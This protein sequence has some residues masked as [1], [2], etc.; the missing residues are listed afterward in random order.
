MAIEN[1]IR[2]LVASNETTEDVIKSL[3]GLVAKGT[4]TQ[5]YISRDGITTRL[6]KVV[7]EGHPL[8][9]KYFLTLKGKKVEASCLE[10]ETQVAEQFFNQCVEADIL[11]GVLTKDRYILY[12]ADHP[13]DHNQ[14]LEVV[15]DDFTHTEGIRQL[16]IIEIEYSGMSEEDA[17]FQIPRP[18]L[19]LLGYEVTNDFAFSNS[20]LTNEEFNDH[21]N[22]IQ[23]YLL[24]C[25]PIDIARIMLER[26]KG[27]VLHDNCA[28]VVGKVNHSLLSSG[29]A[30]NIKLTGCGGVDRLVSTERF[31]RIHHILNFYAEKYQDKNFHLRNWL[32]A[33]FP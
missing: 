26:D 24:E 32:N 9:A 18:I 10:I 16:R 28:F 2:Y 12:R 5:G 6:R 15:L 8:R 20:N 29:T 33:I 1:E 30:F 7:E 27:E 17:L 21:R 3:G 23:K 4:I 14:Y 25:C 13:E 22:H 11:K 19:D 31:L